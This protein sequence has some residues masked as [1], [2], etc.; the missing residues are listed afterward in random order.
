MMNKLGILVVSVLAAV[1]FLVGLIFLG[2]RGDAPS[3]PAKKTLPPKAEIQREIKESVRQSHGSQG[4]AVAADSSRKDGN[5][6]GILTDKDKRERLS[7]AQYNTSMSSDDKIEL[8]QLL[9]E[10][11]DAQFV[12]IAYKAL[13]DTDSDV[14]SAAV[15][16]LAEHAADLEEGK[17]ADELLPLVQKAVGDADPEIR[18]DAVA[19]AQYLRPDDAGELLR[20][21]LSDESDGVREA[22]F[23]T[24]EDMPQESVDFVVKDAFSSSFADVKEESVELI[25]SKPSPQGFE[26][27]IQGLRDQDPELREN[28][29]EAIEFLVSEEFDT[30]EDAASWWAQNKGRYDG[31][32][33]ELD[34]DA[35]SSG[36]P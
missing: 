27:L 2:G 16:A 21:S 7:K 33:S 15:E 5:G 1:I 3:A 24:L 9:L 6:R 35:P 30:A 25:Q 28:V 4:G 23:D 8:L 29:K 18:K 19:I 31:E 13:D 34:D 11:G 14:R 22:V 36:A 12:N 10:E 20:Q 32:M 26:T 17:G